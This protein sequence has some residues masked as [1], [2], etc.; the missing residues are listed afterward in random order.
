MAL[1]SVAILVLSAIVLVGS[2]LP[3]I[4]T[5][6]GI[7]RVCDFPRPQLLIAGIIA[8][9]GVAVVFD[10]HVW[11]ALM[12]ALLCVAMAL[13][14]ARI[15]P[16]LAFRPNKWSSPESDRPAQDVT[17]LISNIKQDNRQSDKLIRLLDQIDPDLALVVEVD[18]WW[19][20]QLANVAERY[21]FVRSSPQ[22][23]GYG[24]M[25]MTRLQ[26]GSCEVR[27]LVRPEIPSIKAELTGPAGNSF[28][29]YGLHPE[30]PTPI[31]DV[32][33]RN[34]ELLIV[35]SEILAER[36]AAVVAGDLNDV[37]WSRTNSRFRRISGMLD[38]RRGR[39]LYATFHADYWFARWPID[40][41]F[42]SSDLTITDLQVLP[43]IGSDHFPVYARLN[44]NDPVSRAPVRRSK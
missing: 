20:N 4:R 31:Q 32:E 11:T 1:L 17:V 38:P 22:D 7:V 33:D 10:W 44:V 12:G 41:V 29:F 3:L 28:T 21:S 35:A 8:F 23:D 14:A 42:H 2:F 43:H 15:S 25:F 5:R 24:L 36:R 26:V 18:D 39:G 6:A 19:E 13:Q 37:A 9:V 16:Y 30:P 27:R 40:H 34:A